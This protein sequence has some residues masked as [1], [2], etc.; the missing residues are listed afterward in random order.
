VPD[1]ATCKGRQVTDGEF[2]ESD[3]Q[4]APDGATI[5]FTST[6]VAEPYY[7]EAGDELYSVPAS[8]GAVAKVAAIEGSI[9]NIAVS[10]DGKRIAFVGTLRGNPIRSYSQSDL[11]IVDTPYTKGSDPGLTLTAKNLTANYDYDIDGGIGGD[12]APPRGGGA[13]SRAGPSPGHPRRPP[14]RLG[15][16]HRTPRPAAPPGG[17]GPRPPPG[18]RPAPPHPAHTPPAP[19]NDITRSKFPDH[20]SESKISRLVSRCP[21]YY[22]GH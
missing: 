2:D 13:R 16:P 22:F 10:P 8:G 21:A 5:Y 20:G 4:W 15:R 7:D 19:S 3:P 11:F 14:G 18:R 1:T 17:R 12:Q 9:A 6:R